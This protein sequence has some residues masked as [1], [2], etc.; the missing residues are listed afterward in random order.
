MRILSREGAR[1]HVSIFFF[2]YIVQ[3]VLLF[4]AETWVVTPC[5]GY[6]LGVSG[7]GVTVTDRNSPAATGRRKLGIYLGGGGDR[8]GGV[9][10][11][12]D[13]YMEE[14]EY[15]CTV[16]CYTIFSGPLLG[17]GEEA[18]GPVWRCGG[19]SRQE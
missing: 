19:G 7:P 10:N 11:H 17:D 14:S 16:H 3:F 13:P 6:A 5:M 12:G 4:G 2:K 15:V 8:G 1:P 18:G 9:G